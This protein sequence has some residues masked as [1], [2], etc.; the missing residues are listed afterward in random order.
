VTPHLA[1]LLAGLVLGVHLVIIGFNIFGLIAIPLG[2][3]RRWRFVRVR[4]W[5]WLHLA[6]MAIVA[7]QALAG[8]VCVLTSLQDRLTGATAAGP[9]LIMG[10]VNRIIFWPLPLWAFAAAYVLLF[11]YV[12]ALMRLVPV[13]P[14]TASM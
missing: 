10:F 5:R 4:W 1:L 9:P 3:W 12:I 14:T 11:G 6:S 8:R 7:L 2:A 13:S